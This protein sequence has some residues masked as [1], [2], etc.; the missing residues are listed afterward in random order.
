M[1]DAWRLKLARLIAPLQKRLYA[2]ARNSRLFSGW[3]TPTSSADAELAMSLDKL[4]DRSRALIRD[5][6]YAKRAKTVVVNNVIGSGIGLQASV[7]NARGT[8]Q[9]SVNEKIEDAW[10]EWCRADTC[11]TGGAL[12][13]SDIERLAVG[14]VFEAGEIF[15][16]LHF[17]AFGRSKVPLALEIIE[18]ERL[19]KDQ[20]V[21]DYEGRVV[22]MGVEVDAFH[23]AVAYW[24]KAGHPGDLRRQL[25]SQ[26][27]FERVPAAQMIHLKGTDLWPQTRGE[28]W[29]HATA[30][31]LN[32]M[33]GYAEAEIVA[34]RASASYMGF[35]K[36]PELPTVEQ[37]D[38]QSQ[39]VME[40]G[41]VQHLAPGEEFVGWA[42]NRPNPNMD[43][44]MRLMLREVAAGVGVSYE[45]LSRDYS[46]SNYSSSRLA[47]LDDRDTWR[48]LQRW[49]IRA[50]REV[51]HGVWMR[52]A[53]NS[54]ALDIDKAAYW[55]NPLKFDA[56]SF[57]ARGWSWVDPT[58]EV[59]AY[60]EAVKAGFTTVGDVIAAT[61][62]GLDLEDVIEARQRE[63]AMMKEAGL[64]FDTDP[65]LLQAD[66]A[67]PAKPAPGEDP[68]AEDALQ[69]GRIYKFKR[70]YWHG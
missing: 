66:P 30:A 16:R 67:A 56:A 50:F 36:S 40:P 23:R 33:D 51:L 60:K 13:F 54:G 21:G 9:E 14:Q 46:Q 62:G 58:K 69:P 2:T 59:E 19:C 20:E 70:R 6:P 35:I 39:V 37:Q 57:K 11:H 17:S 8:L 22:R 34:A 63:L 61:G 27:K 68:A 31:R 10:E 64:V 25:D 38:N 53:V 41:L 7:V 18:P 32:D 42:P 47:L 52:Q 12:H 28:P 44:F 29:L 43:P 48:H 3:V 15:I 4:R 26:Q 45:S 65:S 1:L 55:A 24:I 49:Y 5:N